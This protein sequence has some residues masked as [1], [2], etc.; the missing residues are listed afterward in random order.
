MPGPVPNLR[1][2]GT[3]INRRATQSTTNSKDEALLNALVKQLAAG[4]RAALRALY[5]LTVSLLFSI[6]RGVLS[7]AAD[8]EEVICDVY[9]QVWRTAVQYDEARGSV[10]AWLIMI[11]RSRAIDRQRQ[12]ASRSAANVCDSG[13][14]A[15]ALSTHFAPD[16][17]L[18]T[19]QRGTAIHA[20]I[21]QLSPIRRRLLA[22]AF[23][24]DLSHQEIAVTTDLALGTVKSHIRRALGIL[25][26]ELEKTETFAE[27]EEQG[28]RRIVEYCTETPPAR[29]H[30]AG[31]GVS[32]IAEMPR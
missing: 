23:F 13:E 10:K 28:H 20:A 1:A 32:R 30:S 9:A 4:D 3:H 21:E 18:H 5:K 27:S 6:A 22:L 25:R 8:A 17:L 11:C 31:P 2:S 24:L 12:N 14:R 19:L 16:D 26:K 7:N 15:D 29:Q